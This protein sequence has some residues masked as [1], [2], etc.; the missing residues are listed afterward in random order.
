MMNNFELAV[1]VKQIAEK[2][3]TLYVMG[4]FGAPLTDAAKKRYIERNKYNQKWE[5]RQKIN[6]ATADTFGFDCVCLIKGV[7]WGWCGDKNAIYGGATYDSNGVPDVG[8]DLMITMCK[9]VK[10]GFDDIEIGEAVWCSGHI[11]VYIGGGLAVECTPSWADKVQITAVGNMGTRPGYM[12]RTWTKH[13]K[14]PWVQYLHM[15]DVDFD[16]RVSAADA[17]AVLRAAVG[18]NKLTDAQLLAADMDHDGKVTAADA[19]AALK[20]AVT[21]K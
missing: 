1:K 7:L 13:G 17:R 4:C 8:A 16:G 2:Y 18:L 20:K 9:V 14:L 10:V 21:R 12:T 15:G 11:G 6:A 5:R 19:A 3:K